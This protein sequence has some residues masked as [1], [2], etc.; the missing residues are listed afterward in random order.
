L[1]GQRRG[2]RLQRAVPSRSRPWASEARPEMGWPSAFAAPLT[3]TFPGLP[4]PGVPNHLRR[5]VLA[6]PPIA[7]C[8]EER[9]VH[10]RVPRGLTGTAAYRRMG[11]PG[12]GRC[13]RR[14]SAYGIAATRRLRRAPAPPDAFGFDR[15][16]AKR[17]PDLARSAGELACGKGPSVNP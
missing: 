9:T 8:A 4:D 14:G 17:R 10:D 15:G 16:R 3:T 6:H 13:E 5:L 1:Q 12:E 2:N 7:G 11:S